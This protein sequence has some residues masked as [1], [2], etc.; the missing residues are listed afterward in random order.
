MDTLEVTQSS[1]II[2]LCV[3]KQSNGFYIELALLNDSPRAATVIAHGRLRCATLGKRGFKR[4]LGPIMDIL[5]R[6]SENYAR[7]MGSVE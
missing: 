2:Y 3:S 5:K 4:L 7:V 6:N 1:C